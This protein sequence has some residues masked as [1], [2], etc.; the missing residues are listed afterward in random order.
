MADERKPP[1]K[2]F[3]DPLAD[4]RRKAVY[5][6]LFLSGF[7][8]VL[9]PLARLFKDSTFRVDPVVFGLIYGTTLALLGIEGAAR[10]LGGKS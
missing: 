2:G 1:P 10:L 5:L 7:V 8:T 3:P 4:L 9:D 6:F